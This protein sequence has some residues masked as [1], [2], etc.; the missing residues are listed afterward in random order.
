MK[1]KELVFGENIHIERPIN[2]SSVLQGWRLDEF[3]FVCF[4]LPTLGLIYFS[5]APLCGWVRK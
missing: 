4:I 1:K 2:Q 3:V 5:F